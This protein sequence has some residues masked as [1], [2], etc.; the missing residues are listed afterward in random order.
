MRNF[1]MFITAFLCFVF[2]NDDVDSDDNDNGD[3]N[4]GDYGDDNYDDNDDGMRV[5]YSKRVGEVSLVVWSTSTS[6]IISF[7]THTV[8][9]QMD[10]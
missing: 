5:S 6:V 2:A 8:S 1:I 10:R 9:S 7:I 4:G 3:D